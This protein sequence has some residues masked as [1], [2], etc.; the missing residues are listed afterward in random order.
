MIGGRNT[1]PLIVPP[2]RGHTPVFIFT[3][4]GI[5]LGLHVKD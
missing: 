1:V 4:G 3:E 2:D 5:S